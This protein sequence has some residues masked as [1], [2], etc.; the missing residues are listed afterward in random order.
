M[1]RKAV[2][3]GMFA[4][5]AIFAL[6][7]TSCSG[8]G[9][10]EKVSLTPT[11]QTAQSFDIDSAKITGATVEERA[12]SLVKL[13]NDKTGGF[14]NLHGYPQKVTGKT[15]EESGT[16]YSYVLMVYGDQP[17][18]KKANEEYLNKILSVVKQVVAYSAKFVADANERSIV[19]M[20][21]SYPNGEQEAYAVQADG[22]KMLRTSPI[23]SWLQFVQPTS[24]TVVA[25]DEWQEAQ[26]ISAAFQIALDEKYI[27]QEEFN[28]VVEKLNEM[29]KAQQAP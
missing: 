26:Q 8:G 21:V 5:L 7:F 11:V 17:Q 23:E 14:A 25:Y 1:K 20:Q 18:D 27:S 2:F 9:S 16:I 22:V 24:L 4:V 12:S 15:P 6:V 3:V 29:I 19:R 10:K 28:K 13:L